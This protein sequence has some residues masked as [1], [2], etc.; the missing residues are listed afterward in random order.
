MLQ[1]G[2]N[3]REERLSSLR[4]AHIVAIGI[5]AVLAGAQA[6]FLLMVLGAHHNTVALVDET[7]RQGTLS[8][9]FATPSTQLH[10]GSAPPSARADLRTA[11]DLLTTS[12]SELN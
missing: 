8:Q 2:T 9:H 11:V 7:R 3:V 10:A 4:W 12:Q 1:Q 6:A 5:V